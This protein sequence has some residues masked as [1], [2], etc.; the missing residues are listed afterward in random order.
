MG[1]LLQSEIIQKATTDEGG[2]FTVLGLAA[3]DYD[4]FAAK[5]GYEPRAERVSIRS[6]EQ[7]DITLQLAGV[8]IQRPYSL[9]QQQSGYLQCTVR[10]SPGVPLAGV[11]APGWYTGV[12]SCGV[13]A[14]VIP[15]GLPVYPPD[16][17]ALAFDV[18]DTGL[19]EA[20]L[21]MQWTSTQ[22]LGR[23]LSVVME[24]ED[25]VNDGTPTYGSAVGPS[26]IR[27]YANES[28]MQSVWAA[29][30]LDCG[31]ATKKEGCEFGTRAFGSANT[32]NFDLPV[33]PPAFPV[34]GA[35][36]KRVDVG[37]T[38]DQR[39]EQYFTSFHNMVM[40]ADY[41]ALPK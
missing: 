16:K 2:G 13:V 14:I 5:L 33:D 19:R 1:V 31:N 25:H 9:L 34:V 20:L 36:P 4:V 7:T 23:A 35:P 8:E 3:G 6:G 22:A 26:P 12:N 18:N 10:A 17:F 41:T 30:K 38:Q 15:G 28:V 21:E 39:F 11:I 40:P 29:D 27:V 37:W 32:T 24:A